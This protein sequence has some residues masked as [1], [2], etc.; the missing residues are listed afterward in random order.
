ML[1]KGER[2]LSTPGGVGKGTIRKGQHAMIAKR[3]PIIKTFQSI[4]R[5]QRTEF[6]FSL[7]QLLSRWA[8][9]LTFYRVLSVCNRQFDYRG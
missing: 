9:L 2:G 8:F 7:K 5:Y 1:S 3:K 4:A 6:K